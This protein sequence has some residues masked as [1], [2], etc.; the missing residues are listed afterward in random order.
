MNLLFAPKATTFSGAQRRF[1][2]IHDKIL[3]MQAQKRLWKSCEL[4]V[5]ASR[6]FN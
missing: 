2:K 4:N 1:Q 5:G 6:T 3:Q